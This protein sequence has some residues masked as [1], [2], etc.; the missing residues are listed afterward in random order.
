[1]NKK[2]GSFAKNVYKIQQKYFVDETSICC[3]NFGTTLMEQTVGR[4]GILDS[5][6]S[7]Y[8]RIFLFLTM[9]ISY[10]LEAKDTLTAYMPMRTRKTVDNTTAGEKAKLSAVLKT[11]VIHILGGG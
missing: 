2:P 9:A 7:V 1:M 11:A 8:Q 4:I 6:F 5:L 3:H 10:I